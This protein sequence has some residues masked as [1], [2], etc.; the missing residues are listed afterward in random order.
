MGLND[1]SAE[2]TD[3]WWWGRASAL[4]PAS[5]A[6]SASLLGPSLL[7]CPVSR[8]SEPH[9]ALSKAAVGAQCRC[10]P[11]HSYTLQHIAL[12]H[13]AAAC[14]AAQRPTTL[15]K[16]GPSV[17]IGG[18]LAECSCRNRT[19]RQTNTC[20]FSQAP[21]K[22]VIA[23]SLPLLALLTCHARLICS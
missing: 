11:L 16:G 3:S 22:H 5:T 10:R 1:S 4:P 9:A 2:L 7:N 18:V 8:E 17:T 6:R 21:H 14:T 23:P 19:L 20:P 15:L 12:R 13:S